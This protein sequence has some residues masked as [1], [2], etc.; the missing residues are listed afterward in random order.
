MFLISNQSNFSLYSLYY[1]EA[2]N[3]FAGP[4]SASLRLANAVC[5]KQ[6]SQR[7]QAVGNTMSGLTGPRFE[8][9]TSR[10]KDERIIAQQTGVVRLP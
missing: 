5:F 8:P 4:I 10:S 2:S 7:W 3:E 1:A 9:Q 6:I